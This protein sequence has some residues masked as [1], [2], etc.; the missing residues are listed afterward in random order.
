MNP[1]LDTITIGV[2]D[3]ARA[4]QFYADGFG[5]VAKPRNGD[6]VRFGLAGESATLELCPW[7]T[8]ADDA[9]VSPDTSGFRGFTLSYIVETAEN[10][11][12]MLR[13]LARFGGEVTKPPRFAVWGYSAHV[14]DPSGHLWKIASPKR[15]PLI[16]RKRTT[17][18]VP[19]PVRAQEVAL[20]IGVADMKRAKQFYEDGLGNPTKKA[21]SKF[22]SFDGDGTPDLALYTWDALADDA[23]VAP[24]GSGFRGFRI[25]HTVDS[26]EAVETL[27]ASA[28]RA[29]G[30]VLRRA[31]DAPGGGN[32]AYFTDPDGYLWRIAAR[33]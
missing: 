8:L 28:K 17:D 31:F 7:D 32:S 18:G 5:L 20:T 11:D 29:G 6:C 23:D 30:K 27:L 10:V 25:S 9:G 4:A 33:A 15:R 14:T 1:K 19:D 13:R 22:V 2:T 12:D 26:V 3:P 24:A 21:Y 16:N